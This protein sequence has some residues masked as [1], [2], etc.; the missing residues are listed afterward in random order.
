[1]VIWQIELKKIL[2][3]Y[4]AAAI[5]ARHCGEIRSTFQTHRDVAKFCECPEVATWPAAKI[6]YGEGRWAFDALQQR[7]DVL[8]DVVIARAR[9]EIFGT[10]VVMI[11][12]DV[13]DLL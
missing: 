8:L 13:A 9:P 5:G 3:P 1:M 10:L 6:Y 7:S 12:R 11:Q 4:L 2:S